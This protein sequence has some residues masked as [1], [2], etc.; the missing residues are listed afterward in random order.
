MGSNAQPRSNGDAVTWIVEDGVNNN[1]AEFLPVTDVMRQVAR[2]ISTLDELYHFC[3]CDEQMPM[4][5]LASATSAGALLTQAIEN[6]H[7]TQ[8]VRR[9]ACSAVRE[10]HQRG[11]NEAQFL[12]FSFRDEPRGELF[13]GDEAWDELKELAKLQGERVDRS[14]NS[15]FIFIEELQNA[16]ARFSLGY[17]T[18]DGTEEP[19]RNTKKTDS[20]TVI[21]YTGR[22]T[23]VLVRPEFVVE[24]R[25]PSAKVTAQAGGAG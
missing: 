25:V 18:R 12:Q 3:T 17:S 9:L 8:N 13:D 11:F 10:I 5:E 20:V 22:N 16:F 15:V 1:R 23:G 24:P 2:A 21:P 7:T 14:I 19:P 4:Q 6:A